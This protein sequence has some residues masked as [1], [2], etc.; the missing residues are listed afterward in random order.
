VAGRSAIITGGGSGIGRACALLLARDGW[1]VTIA[2]R[3]VA[4]GEAARDDILAAKGI[5]QFVETDVLEEASVAAMTD[6]AVAAYE[7]PTGA[8]NCAGVG[9]RGLSIRDMDLASWDRTV[10]INL[11]GM[12]LCVKYQTMAMWDQGEGSIVALSSAAATMGLINSSDYC[13]SKAGITGLV[14]GAAID[15]APRNIR[16]NALLP[17]ATDTPLARRSAAET[18]GLAGT[19]TVPLGRMASAE[20]MAKTAIWLLSDASTYVTGTCISAD[21][22]LT[23][24]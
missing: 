6:R 9:Q 15:C 11:R 18:P 22:G 13:A 3:D 12:F 10:G 7:V 24:A 23:I 17:G 14:R 2:D 5:A 16:V 20:E 1:A 4:G 21:G 8:I 19:L